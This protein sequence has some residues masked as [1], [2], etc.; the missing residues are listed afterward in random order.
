MALLAFRHCARRVF[1]VIVICLAALAVA[2]A[3][4]RAADTDSTTKKILVAHRGASGYAPEHTIESYELAIKQGADFVEQDLQITKDG[5][6]VCLHDESLERTTNV[7]EMF[8]DRSTEERAGGAT[9]KR[10]FVADFTLREIKQLDAGSWFAP[11]F[12]GARVPTFGEAI[13]LIRG[14]AGLYPETKAPEVYGRRGFDMERLLLAELK[15]PGLDR[16][17]A[18]G[19]TP[20]IIQ[21]FSA[22]SLRKM[23]VELKTELPLVLLIGAENKDGWLTPSGLKRARE[24]AR[25]IGPAKA[26]VN[27]SIVKAARA[28]GLTITPYTFRSRDTGQFTSVREEMNHFLYTLGVD[29]VFTDNPDEFPRKSLRR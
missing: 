13:K 23:R 18:D 20:V 19:R 22:A 9:V 7:E 8:P 3:T 21:S 4:H 11:Q 25:G 5:V 6:L 15:R 17:G 1:A 24:F 29:A 12:K 26:L 27:A 14:R 2:T 16:P 28:A 10:W